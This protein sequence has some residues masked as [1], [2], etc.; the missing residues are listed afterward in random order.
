M[1]EHKRDETRPGIQS[2]E[3]TAMEADHEEDDASE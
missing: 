3:K 1:M 2:D